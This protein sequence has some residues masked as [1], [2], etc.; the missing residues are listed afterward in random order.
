MLAAHPDNGDVRYAVGLLALQLQ[1]YATAETALKRLLQMG[2]RDADGVRFTLGQAAEEQK[3]W[4]E[5]AQ[6]Q[7]RAVSE[8]EKDDALSVELWFHLGEIERDFYKARGYMPAWVDGDG[9]T[10][11][12]KDLVQ[13]LHCYLAA[14]RA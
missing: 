1:D 14:C 10:D 11:Q 6:Q 2:F 4:D 9:T 7:T 8:A 5:A 13:Q 3:K 12:W